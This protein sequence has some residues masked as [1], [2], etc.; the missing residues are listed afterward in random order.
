MPPPAQRS[1]SRAGS[2]GSITIAGSDFEVPGE[3]KLQTNVLL[4]GAP[5][6]G[7]TTFVTMHMP[8]PIALINFDNRDQHAVSRAVKAGKRIM[9][10]HIGVPGNITKMGD[11]IVRSTGQNAVNKVIKNFELAVAESVKGNVRTICLDTGTEYNEVLKMAVTG[12]IDKVVGDFGKSKD[13]MNREWWRL[14]AMAREGK[15][16]FV[17]LAR[18][19]AIWKNQEPTGKFTYRGPEVMDDAA[20]WAANIRS[21]QRRDGKKMVNGFE[22][23]IT[24]SGIDISQLGEVYSD[25]VWD[26]MGGPFVHAC[27]MQYE[28]SVD[29]DWT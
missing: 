19:K 20:D 29:S 22:M 6:S 26:V 2:A 1:A 23:E 8:D 21:R 15:A 11:A 17:V 25:E 7:K 13:L 16:H 5:A 10:T 24:K 14:F 27:T 28:G 9:R 3:P 18:A 4:F 12:R